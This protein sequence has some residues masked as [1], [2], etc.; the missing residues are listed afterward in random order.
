MIIYSSCQDESKTYYLTKSVIF[1]SFELDD[2]FFHQ[3][4]FGRY[5]LVFPGAYRVLINAQ[6][7]NLGSCCDY[8]M[9]FFLTSF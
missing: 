5:A 8:E 6:S 1:F 2:L 7:T 4:L 9:C 3:F